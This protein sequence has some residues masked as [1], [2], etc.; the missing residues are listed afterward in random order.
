MDTTER[1]RNR[2]VERKSL[3]FPSSV[4]PRSRSSG[5]AFRIRE[6]PLL[7]GFVYALAIEIGLALLFGGSWMLIHHL[8]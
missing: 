3:V 1:D 8:R 2:S 4:A 6:A 7:R 5:T